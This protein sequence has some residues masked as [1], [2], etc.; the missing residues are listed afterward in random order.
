VPTFEEDT[1]TEERGVP[2]SKLANAS[3]N[4][5]AEARERLSMCDLQWVRE[6]DRI[7]V[8]DRPAKGRGHSIE[9]KH[10]AFIALVGCAACESR[11]VEAQ[12]SLD[13]YA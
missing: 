6:N 1:A 11:S 12:A 5:Y 7:V 13:A 3:E 10:G 2:F 9:S 4:P 8:E